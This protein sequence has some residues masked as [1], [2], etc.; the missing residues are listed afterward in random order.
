MFGLKMGQAAS[1]K[2][3]FPKHLIIP[4]LADLEFVR[5]RKHGGLN[6]TSNDLF[7]EQ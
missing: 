7:M 2:S 3:A 5:D 1:K 4:G 6:G